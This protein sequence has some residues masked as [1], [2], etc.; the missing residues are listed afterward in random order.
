MFHASLHVLRGV[1]KVGTDKQPAIFM[2]QCSLSRDFVCDTQRSAPPKF[3]LVLVCF[4]EHWKCLVLI[5]ESFR[6]FIRFVAVS[7]LVF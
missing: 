7:Y 5:Q 3:L 1:E 2:L 4:D 6:R